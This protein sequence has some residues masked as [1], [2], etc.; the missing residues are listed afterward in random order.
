MRASARQAALPLQCEHQRIRTRYRLVQERTRRL[1]TVTQRLRTTPQYEVPRIAEGLLECGEAI[2]AHHHDADPL[3][4]PVGLIDPVGRHCAAASR[5][6]DPLERFEYLSS[7]I[8]QV[9]EILVGSADSDI[10]G[11]R[12]RERLVQH[13]P[14]GSTW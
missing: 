6:V 8:V 13:A 5:A 7:E 10:E 12:R 1:T 14:F 4:L 11:D 9:G 3:V 2:I